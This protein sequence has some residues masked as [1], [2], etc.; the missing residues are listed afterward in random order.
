MDE[1][2]NPSNPERCTPLSEPFKNLADG[3][4]ISENL[5][6]GLLKWFQLAGFYVR[7]CYALKCPFLLGRLNNFKHC[8]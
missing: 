7:C 8:I 1:V 6:A 3:I 2:Q 4:C 5:I